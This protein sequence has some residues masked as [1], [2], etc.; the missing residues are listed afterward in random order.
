LRI[1]TIAW[2]SLQSC[3]VYTVMFFK[4]YC[5]FH[6]GT[7]NCAN[8]YHKKINLLHLMESHIIFILH[9]YTCFNI[10][11]VLMQFSAAR[12]LFPASLY[13]HLQPMVSKYTLQWRLFKRHINS[14]F[15][16]EE[17]THRSAFWTHTKIGFIMAHLWCSCMI[18][19]CNTKF[20]FLRQTLTPIYIE[21]SI[22]WH[23]VS[24]CLYLRP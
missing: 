17:C 12:F 24:I 8:L 10:I 9:L 21:S 5:I 1:L 2:F 3:D 13:M 20:T 15:S 4:A 14:L 23:S 11:S 6:C 19:E 7:Y 22:R 18:S 16:I